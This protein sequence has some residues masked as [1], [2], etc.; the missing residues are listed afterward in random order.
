MN[1][2]GS[3]EP[4]TSLLL[5]WTAKATVL[6][7]LAFIAALL[8][9]RRS[10]AL[11]HRIWALAIVGSLALPVVALVIPSWHVLSAPAGMAANVSQTVIVTSVVAPPQVSVA[12][13]R[14][15]DTEALVG[16]AL[17]I[18][19]LGTMFI[20]CRLLAGFARLWRISAYSKRVPEN[21]CIVLDELCAVFGVRRKIRLL[22]SANAATMPMTWGIFRPRIVLPADA[23]DWDDERRRIVLSHEL[24]HVSRADWPLQI[25][26]ETLRTCFWF[27]PLAWIA[28]NQM[29]QESE[30]A[31]D[32]AVLNSGIT[33]P[34]YASQLLALAKA[35]KAPSW[36]FSLA[37]AIARPSNLERRFAALLDRSVSRNPLSRRAGVLA[38]FC[39]ACVLLPVAAL[40]LSAE[41]P[42]QTRTG[43]STPQTA[44]FALSHG[45]AAAGSGLMR[46][47]KQSTSRAAPPRRVSG[48]EPKMAAISSEARPNDGQAMAAVQA[49]AP[50]VVGSISGTVGD[51]SGAIVAG[52]QVALTDVVTGQQQQI[53]ANAAGEFNF[54]NLIP[55]NYELTV[56]Q[57]GFQVYKQTI[58]LSPNEALSL[59][60]LLLSVGAVAQTVEVSASRSGSAGARA[61]PSGMVPVSAC[62]ASLQTAQ[63]L[64]KNPEQP[65]PGPPPTRIRVRVGGNVQ[66]AKLVQQTMPIY[67]DAARSAGIQGTVVMNAIIGKDGTLLSACV[68]SGSPSLAKS[69]LDAVSQWHYS[70]ALLNGEPVE[71]MTEIQ[72][73]FTLRD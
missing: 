32:D 57:P 33:A 65:Q 49:S 64:Y 22:E 5:T 62:P 50:G 48:V 23:A 47:G 52:A 63:V 27:H 8:L 17:L 60:E 35:L 42:I 66:F 28:A 43:V 46:S 56:S 21:A 25:C 16:A 31:C 45:Q 4:V 15:L 59:S 36:R 40:T 72:V 14:G 20:A 67:P 7:G 44:I 54:S 2:A 38:T 71:V 41:A 51:P 69:A 3:Y 13:G 18:W 73:V 58:Q 68:A 24:A 70:P 9:R 19:A 12:P 29:R 55:D 61:V 53:K 10:A 26:A 30:R 34:E 39:G 11:R 1:F 6:L 37:L